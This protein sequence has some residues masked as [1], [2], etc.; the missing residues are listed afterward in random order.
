MRL[1]ALRVYQTKQNMKKLLVPAAL[2]L[3]VACASPF[4]KE[5]E[6]TPVAV[7][8]KNSISPLPVQKEVSASNF[9]PSSQQEKIAANKFMLVFFHMLYL[10]IRLLI[11]ILSVQ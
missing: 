8:V 10:L 5:K 7:A 4:L 2:L 9:S 3:I 6:N 11:T 1:P